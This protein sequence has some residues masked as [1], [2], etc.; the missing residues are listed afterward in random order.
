M[1]HQAY[2]SI[3]KLIQAESAARPPSSSR[4]LVVLSLV[5]S[6]SYSWSRGLRAPRGR[7]GTCS[8]MMGVQA[9]AASRARW[10][11]NVWCHARGLQTSWPPSLMGRP[12]DGYGWRDA[13]TEESSDP[14]CHLLSQA[15]FSVFASAR[16]TPS[17]RFALRATLFDAALTIA[18]AWA[19]LIAAPAVLAVAPSC[20]P[21][22][23]CSLGLV[24]TRSV[25]RTRKCRA[26]RALCQREPC[27]AGQDADAPQKVAVY[28]GSHPP[29]D[30]TDHT[31]RAAR[32]HGHGPRGQHPKRH[33]KPL[34]SNRTRMANALQKAMPTEIRT[35]ALKNCARTSGTR[36]IPTTPGELPK[37]TAPP[38]C[39]SKRSTGPPMD[40]CGYAHTP[41]QCLLVS[42]S[43]PLSL[44]AACNRPGSTMLG[45][46]AFQT[47][48][49]T[50]PPPP[51]GQSPTVS[52]TMRNARGHCAA[53]L[54]AV[55][56]TLWLAELGSNR[57]A[58]MPRV[59]WV[60]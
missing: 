53:P 40:L 56:A 10:P 44:S 52:Q 49:S 60:G 17:L 50:P 26:R 25:M 51:L 55:A 48:T 34:E 38:S 7:A 18:P 47:A 4:H 54:Q 6:W 35:T 41:L 29:T 11:Q 3:P 33:P 30:C 36:Q 59:A 22:G 42:L 12:S 43:R 14:W 13:A 46:P 19:R 45:A 2:P 28:I 16:Q 57:C 31:S 8:A 27:I 58:A 15:G 5:L 39:M 23:S 21:C 1:I 24:L 20:A 37:A 32:G 9:L